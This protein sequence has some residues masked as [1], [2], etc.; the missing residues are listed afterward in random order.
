MCH[1]YGT[2]TTQ[3]LARTVG[4]LRCIT[5][6][7]NRLCLKSL[8]HLKTCRNVSTKSL[9]RHRRLPW[10]NILRYDIRSVL[11]LRTSEAKSSIRPC[12][13]LHDV[14]HHFVRFESCPEIHSACEGRAQDIL[15]IVAGK[16]TDIECGFS[17]QIIARKSYA[18]Q[19]IDKIVEIQYSTLAMFRIT[20]MKGL[21]SEC[22]LE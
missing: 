6:E 2:R 21:S 11:Y 9:N 13:V 20:G 16:F 4:Q 17:K 3:D 19:G 14:A 7:R 15:R 1:Q 10:S 8:E 12:H 18:A 5:S 22:D